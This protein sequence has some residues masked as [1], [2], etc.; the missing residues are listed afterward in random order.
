MQL[1]YLLAIYSIPLDYLIVN[2]VTK[3]KRKIERARKA[4]EPVFPFQ[5]RGMGGNRAG[6]QKCVDYLL[7][8]HVRREVPPM[9]S[10]GKKF[11]VDPGAPSGAL[12]DLPCDM[13]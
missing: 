8:I 6:M 2:Q 10:V 13:V 4:S 11:I 5:R 3:E 7:H 9:L 1:D 12:P